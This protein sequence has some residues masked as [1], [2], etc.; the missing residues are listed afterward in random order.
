MSNLNN[1]PVESF[2]SKLRNVIEM[3][4]E[5]TLIPIEM[6]GSTALA[7]LSL[8][9]QP[10]LEVASPYG[11]KKSE[12]CSLYFLTLAKSGEGKSPLRELLMAP[13]DEF[14]SEMHEEYEKFLDVYKKDYAIWSSKEKALNRNYQKAVKNGGGR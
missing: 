1:Y 3:L 10:L 11:N 4:H 8:A 13:F 9:L 14:A 5:D 7:A 6:I 2:P 12:P